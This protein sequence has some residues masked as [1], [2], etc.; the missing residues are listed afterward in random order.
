VRIYSSYLFLTLELD[1]GEWSASRL[2]R[3]LV[4]GKGPPVPIGGCVGP[5]AGVDTEARGKIY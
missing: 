3:S 1:V 5:K 2:S 4:P